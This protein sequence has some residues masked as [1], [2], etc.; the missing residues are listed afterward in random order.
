MAQAEVAQNPGS[1]TTRLPRRDAA[2]DRPDA[3]GRRRVAIERVQPQIDCGRFPVKRV[4]GDVVTVEADIMSDGHDLLDAVLKHWDSGGVLVEHPMTLVNN[5]RWRATFLVAGMGLHRYAVEAWV[6]HFATWRAGLAKKVEAGLDDRETRIELKIG[7]PFVRRAAERAEGPG[8]GLLEYWAGILEGPA[9]L[10]ATLQTA[11]SDEVGQTMRAHAE[12]RFSATSPPLEVRVDPERARSSAWYEMF[13]RSASPVPGKQGSFRDC[14]ERL[15]YVAGMGFD[16]LYLPPIHPIGLTKRKGKNNSPVAEPDD[17]GSPWAIGSALGGHKDVDLQLGT[18]GEFKEL[19][20]KCRALGMDLAL[21]LAFQCSADHPY[22]RSNPEWF[23]M[24]PDGTIQYAENPPKKYQDIYPF[25][26]ETEHWRELW[27]ELKDVMLYWIAQGVRIFR[28]D[29]P[30]TKPFAFWAWLIAGVK[31]DYPDVLFLAEAFTRPKIMYRLAKLG[32]SHSYTYFAWRNSKTD[33]IEYLKELTTT[34]VREFFRPH[35]WPNTPDILTNELQTGGRPA[36][37]SRLVLAATL[38]ANYGIYGPPFEL[39]ENR[40]L[41]PG[42]EEYLNAEKYEIRHWDLDRPDSLRE[43][44]ARVNQARREHPALRRDDTLRFHSTDNDQLLAYSKSTP[45]LSDIVLMV[46]NLDPFN[47]RIGRTDLS[48]AELGLAPW[49]AYRVRDLLT[50]N[51]YQWQG[52]RNYIELDPRKIPAHVF[53]I[54]R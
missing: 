49:Q 41:V 17:V 30:H 54:R 11:L 8:R 38:S 33:L 18:V 46:V 36:F 50:G 40:A 29:N 1:E 37:M 4:V 20:G 39:M 22:L 10:K 21:D 3:E 34:G 13:P 32:F 24:R 2:A 35:F 16:V 15:P 23:L 12:R 6:D 19:L 52:A 27:H 9:D 44:I 53:H 26:F 51:E 45:D 28:V 48:L 43:F 25:N 47:T 42:K 7:A 31:R 14:I 5:D